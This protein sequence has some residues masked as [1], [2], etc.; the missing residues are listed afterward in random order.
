M[1]D[2]QK[3]PREWVGK[4]TVIFFGR[5]NTWLLYP[6][7]KRSDRYRVVFNGREIS[8]A[9]GFSDLLVLIRKAR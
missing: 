9:I 8:K 4:I 7:R 3:Y 2:K 1:S 6:S 5:T